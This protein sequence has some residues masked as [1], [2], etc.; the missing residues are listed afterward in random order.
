MIALFAAAGR[1]WGRAGLTV[2]ADTDPFPTASPSWGGVTNPRTSWDAAKGWGEWG[3]MAFTVMPW[4][5][6]QPAQTGYLEWI[7]W[8]NLKSCYPVWM[9][10]LVPWQG[11][12]GGW[13]AALLWAHAMP[14]EVRVLMW[15]GSGD[16]S[17]NQLLPAALGTALAQGSPALTACSALRAAPPGST[18]PHSRCAQP[19]F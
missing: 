6:K 14:S 2:G 15:A 18:G 13:A 1:N 17:P 5:S 8:C 4:G 9:E 19:Y 3:R 11:G 12:G 16:T 7:N 10:W